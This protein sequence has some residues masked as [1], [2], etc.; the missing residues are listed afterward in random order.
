MSLIHGYR[1]QDINGRCLISV[2]SN[3][4]NDQPIYITF[5]GST[6]PNH[7]MTL[8]SG[9]SFT[10]ILEAKGELHHVS[11]VSVEIR[12]VDKFCRFDYQEINESE[13]FELPAPPYEIPINVNQW[14]LHYGD[15]RDLVDNEGWYSFDSINQHDPTVAL[16]DHVGSVRNVIYRGQMQ[17]QDSGDRG[18]ALGLM[19][20]EKISIHF[21]LDPDNGR[22]GYFILPYYPKDQIEVK[23]SWSNFNGENSDYKWGGNVYPFEGT[24]NSR[25]RDITNFK[26]RCYGDKIAVAVWVGD[27]EPQG[28]Q[29]E[30][31]IKD[32]QM[33]DG[34]EHEDLHEGK[35]GFISGTNTGFDDNRSCNYRNLQVEHII[36]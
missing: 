3:S 15:S 21:G 1:S 7:L 28:Y 27:D 23:Q 2:Q 18:L 30:I 12:E 9:R 11:S 22:A 8:P 14:S 13:I 20:R 33:L 6:T 31:D 36:V 16:N 4:E 19:V 29:I 34:V 32:F 26:I 10:A 17:N 35:V 25:Y 24:E 5:D